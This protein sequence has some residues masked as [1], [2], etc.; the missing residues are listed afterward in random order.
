MKN[1]PLINHCRTID[2]VQRL[3]QTSTPITDDRLESLLWGNSSTL[4][5]GEET[6][7]FG[8]SL[9]VGNLPIYNLL[10]ICIL[11]KTE[12][13]EDHHPFSFFLMTSAMAFIRANR[14]SF[15]LKRQPNTV[16]LYDS[17]GLING[18]F[19]IVVDYLLDL[20]NPLI[21]RAQSDR[22]AHTG[23]PALAD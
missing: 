2:Q 3:T 7:P 20:V 10:F 18:L 16:E 22:A 5:L 21:D 4:E 23:T 8:M 6:L 19:M 9:T 15:V 12:G 17:R 1:A 11:P 13:N 14:S